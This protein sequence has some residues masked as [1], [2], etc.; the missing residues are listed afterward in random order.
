MNQKISS[1]PIIATSLL[2]AG[3]IL[4]A[5]YLLKDSEHAQ[6]V[7]YLLIA[8]WCIPFSMLSKSKKTCC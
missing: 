6:T 8:A 5:S 2:F 3:A 7:T 4:I 1:I